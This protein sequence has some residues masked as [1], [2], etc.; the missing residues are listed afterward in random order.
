MDIAELRKSLPPGAYIHGHRLDVES[1]Q[2]ITEWEHDDFKTGYTFPTS[3]PL[4]Q[5]KARGVPQGVVF[6][7]K[8]RGERL[9]AQREETAPNLTKKEPE[10][11]EAVAPKSKKSKNVAQAAHV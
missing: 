11:A 9:E 1:G 4:E 8:A 5:L 7:G 6:T 2:V 10:N 3:F